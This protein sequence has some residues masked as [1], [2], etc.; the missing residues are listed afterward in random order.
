MDIAGAINVLALTIHAHTGAAA[1]R[2][3]RIRSR[4]IDFNFHT[5]NPR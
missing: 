1:S 4:I 5:T 3:M 2:N